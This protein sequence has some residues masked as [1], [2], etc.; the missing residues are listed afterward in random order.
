MPTKTVPLLMLNNELHRL[1][2][3]S[4]IKDEETAR[5]LGCRGTKISRIMNMASRPSVADVKMMG[6]LYGASPEQLAMLMDLARNLGR[7]GDWT[8]YKSVYRESARLLIDMEARCDEL[9]QARAEILPGLLQTEDYIRILSRLPSPYGFAFNEEECVQAR[10]AR[11]ATLD[12]RVNA[13]FILAESALR[14]V[15]GDHRVMGQQMRHLMQVAQRPNVRIQVLPYMCSPQSSW[16]WLS[17]SMIHVPSPGITA[18]LDLV[19]LEQFDDERFIDDPAVVDKYKR[20][21]SSLAGASLC[22]ME[23]V[24]FIGK[25]AEEYQ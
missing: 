3:K 17:F 14:R 1:K 10:L 19:H 7:K 25:M 2:R 20:L 12:R 23:S 15:Y 11:Q 22:P 8:G 5:Y 6:E 4:G 21:W 24:D 18:P 9:R 13:S 16:G